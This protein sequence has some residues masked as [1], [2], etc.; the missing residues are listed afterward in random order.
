M[1]VHFVRLS[2]GLV[3]NTVDQADL[4]CP[5]PGQYAVASSGSSDIGDTWTGSVFTKPAAAPT[6]VPGFVT[7]VRARLALLAANKLSAVQPAID[8][9]SEPQRSQAQV[10]WNHSP[11]VERANPFCLLLGAAIGLSDAEIDA[12]FIAAANL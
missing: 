8:A 1:R 2:D 5:F 10:Y 3:V 4:S 11:S 6:P 7:M 9:L 12:L